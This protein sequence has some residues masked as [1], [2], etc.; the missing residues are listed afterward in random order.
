LFLPALCC[1]SG[2]LHAQALQPHVFVSVPRLW[3][4]IYDRVMATMREA[5]PVK[6]RLFERA[7]AYKRAALE[8]GAAQQVVVCL[9]AI[10]SSV[11]TLDFLGS[12]QL[13]M[14]LLLH[15]SGCC[16]LVNQSSLMALRWL[17]LA[18]SAG[19]L[20]GGRWGPFWD[21]LV[22]SKVRER[23]GGRV[24][25]MTTGEASQQF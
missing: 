20:S 13:Y 17:A 5:N 10:R 11:A 16:W 14:L 2:C 19:D 23:L 15:L 18:C 6:R 24:K 4:R 9:Q 25:Y 1:C 21:R 22:F 3:N 7:F 12:P 8:A